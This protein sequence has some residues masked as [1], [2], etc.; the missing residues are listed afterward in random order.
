MT[1]TA[2]KDR[3]IIFSARNIPLLMDGRKTQTRRKVLHP[4]DPLVHA[5]KITVDEQRRVFQHVGPSRFRVYRRGINWRRYKEEPLKSPFH[6]GQRLWVKETWSPD[7]KQFY[8]HFPVVYKADDPV[9]P[10]EIEKGKVYSPE[11]KSWYPFRWRSPIHMPRSASRITLEITDVRVQRVQEIS[12][13]DA[14]AEG[15]ADVAEFRR[16]WEAIHGDAAWE[17]NSW[18]WAITFKRIK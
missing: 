8:P 10:S 17:Q 16:L 5:E 2:T 9:S 3:P 1:T 4:F 18:V 11:S 15:C 12:E 14:R 6:A 7:H 13:N